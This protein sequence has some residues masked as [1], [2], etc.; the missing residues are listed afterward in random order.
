MS[1]RLDN[2]IRENEESLQKISNE[3]LHSIKEIKVVM[4][5]KLTEKYK[6]PDSIYI[7]SDKTYN[8]D[9][10]LRDDFDCCLLDKG[11]I[12]YIYF[13]NGQNYVENLSNHVV[14]YIE[15]INYLK[16]KFSEEK[17]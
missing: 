17:I 4:L 3:S 15:R 12:A 6:M 1:S 11:K 2:K 5:V 14:P 10:I 9:D 13:C 7:Q 8:T 16:R